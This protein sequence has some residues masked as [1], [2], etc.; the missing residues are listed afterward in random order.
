MLYDTVATVQGSDEE[1]ISVSDLHELLTKIH[2]IWHD[3][4]SKQDGNKAHFSAYLFDSAFKQCHK[5]ELYN[6]FF[7]T[8]IKAVF[9]QV[10]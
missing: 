3:A 9:L 4:L 8:I 7:F 5:S 6:S 2:Y 1:V 10:R